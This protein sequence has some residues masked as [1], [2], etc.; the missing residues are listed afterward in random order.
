[1][2]PIWAPGIGAAAHTDSASVIRSRRHYLSERGEESLRFHSEQWQESGRDLSV[3]PLE[4]HVIAAQAEIHR[5]PD[6]PW[7]PPSRGRLRA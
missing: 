7:A 1:M 6:E 4:N 3:R 5:V 2:P